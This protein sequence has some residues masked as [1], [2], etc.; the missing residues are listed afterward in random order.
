MFLRQCR[1]RDVYRAQGD[2]VINTVCIERLNTTFR[3]RLASLTRRGR[4][5]TRH[6]LTVQ[7]GRSLIG[8]VYSFCTPHASLGLP[9]PTAGASGIKRTPA[10]AAG[11]TDHCWT[12]RELNA[13]LPG[14]A[15]QRPNGPLDFLSPPIPEGRNP[16]SSPSA[17][18][19]PPLDDASGI[20][21]A[22]LL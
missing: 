13:E 4:A 21:V 10:L 19:R 3:T 11:L 20:S 1:A 5:L 14:F 9:A 2:G 17:P 16:R 18:E 15:A 8:T 22:V 6:T 7:H 12:V